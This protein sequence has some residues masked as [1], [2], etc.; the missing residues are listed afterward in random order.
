[1]MLQFNSCKDK[2]V[3]IKEQEESMKAPDNLTIISS[4]ESFLMLTW[5][6]NSTA[7]IEYVVENESLKEVSYNSF[8]L[9]YE[10]KINS[11]VY[12]KRGLTL[13][14]GFQDLFDK[15]ATDNFWFIVLGMYWVL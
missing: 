5:Q 8:G 2:L 13:K 4:S 7:E 1:M 3:D 14:G 10:I 6:D 11:S 12:G 9:Y 15:K